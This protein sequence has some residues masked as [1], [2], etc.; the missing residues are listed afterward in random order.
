MATEYAVGITTYV[1]AMEAIRDN[2]KIAKDAILAMEGGLVAAEQAGLQDAIGVGLNAA[3]DTTAGQR[4]YTLLGELVDDCY[5]AFAA[6]YDTYEQID[7]LEY[8]EG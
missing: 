1:A 5:L 8:P 4:V 2:I 7:D 3:V 6:L